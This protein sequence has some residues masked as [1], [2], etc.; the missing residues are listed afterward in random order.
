VIRYA[1]LH[2]EISLLLERDRNVKTVEAEG[3][4]PEEALSKASELFG[5]VPKRYLEYEIL[6]RQQSFMG[7]G[8][9][10]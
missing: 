3:S 6:E 7:V 1:Q 10:Y 5:G 4:T 8:T 2:D 9:N